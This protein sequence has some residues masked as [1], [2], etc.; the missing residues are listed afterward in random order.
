VPHQLELRE[1]GSL[2]EA[3]EITFGDGCAITFRAE[4]GL[5]ERPSLGLRHGTAACEVTG[6]RGR[7]EGASGFV[8]SNFLLYD[9]GRLTDRR[10]GLLFV[11]SRARGGLDHAL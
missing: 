3:G 11:D 2:A 10:L 6:G 7:L 8:V 4:G 9:S 1:D 5:V